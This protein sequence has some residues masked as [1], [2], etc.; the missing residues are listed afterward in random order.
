MHRS[1]TS[2]VIVLAAAAICGCATGKASRMGGP[3]EVERKANVVDYSSEGRLWFIG[4]N[5]RVS[6]MAG[7]QELLPLQVVIVNKNA[8]PTSLIREGF[9]LETPDG[10]RLPVISYD[11]FEDEYRRDRADVAAGEDYVDRFTTRF[12]QP[13]FTW[14]ELEFFPPRN[15]AVAP[16]EEMEVREG[17]LVHGYLYFARP[18]E[19]YV[20]PRDKYKLLFSPAG[21]DETLV[22]ELF[23]F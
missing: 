17:E 23:P 9:V 2:C 16:R 15:S 14:R 5:A 22:V 1:G 13:P 6:R 11:Q 3:P 10:K 12:P 18:D 21:S 19:S 8:G 7:P 4:V 20:F